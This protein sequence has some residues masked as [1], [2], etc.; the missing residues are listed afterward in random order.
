[1]STDT[2]ETPPV[3]KV[4]DD[5]SIAQSREKLDART[6]DSCLAF[7]PVNRITILA[8]ICR[9]MNFDPLKSELLRRLEKVSS[10]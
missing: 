2:T 3:F 10:I 9:E 6:R 5:K 7:P 1:M 4:A 8:R